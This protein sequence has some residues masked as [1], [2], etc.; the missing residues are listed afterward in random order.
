MTSFLLYH[1]STGPISLSYGESRF[2]K[3]KGMKA[4]GGLL[5]GRTPGG[6]K[7]TREDDEGNII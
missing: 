2:K 4:E 7:E 1:L 5:S 6:K 3:R